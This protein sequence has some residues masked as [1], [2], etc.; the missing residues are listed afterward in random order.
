MVPL[1]E[2]A[3]VSEGATLHEAV[4]AL[5]KAQGEFNKFL[6][7]A[8]EEFGT[9]RHPH[10]AILVLDKNGQVAGKVSQLDA[11]RALEPKYSKMQD[12]RGLHRYG[13]TK[14]FMK[15]LLKTY[16]LWNSPLEDI[17]AKADKI[18]V[19]D[20]MYIPTEGEYVDEDSSYDEAIHQLVLGHHQSLL[21]T[22]AGKITGILRLTDVFEAV[23]F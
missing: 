16:E 8:P 19:S 10:R 7:N 11:L 13:F 22:K 4:I 17:R 5:E 15:S 12:R 14:T 6:E 20:F 1:S 3:T 18:S 2:Y 23:F 9:K 21:V